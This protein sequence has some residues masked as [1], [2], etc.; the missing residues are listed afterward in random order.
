MTWYRWR[1]A[2]CHDDVPVPQPGDT[3]SLEAAMDTAGRFLA[4]SLRGEAVALIWSSTVRGWQPVT[5]GTMG[6]HR[7]E[8]HPWPAGRLGAELAAKATPELPTDVGPGVIGDVIAGKR[9]DD[10][11]TISVDPGRPSRVAE[12]AAR[13]RT[14]YADEQAA[15]ALPESAI[16]SIPLASPPHQAIE[17][18]PAS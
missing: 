7:M 18:D 6:E 2:D 11:V 3:A 8:W 5:Y 1:I 14:L 13:N 16:D 15:Q 12:T 4:T 10:V 17:A 9:G